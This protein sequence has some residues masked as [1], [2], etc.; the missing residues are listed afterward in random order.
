MQTLLRLR[1]A[2]LVENR[3]SF[4][5]G[6]LRHDLAQGKELVSNLLYKQDAAF[7]A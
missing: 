1:K 5:G 4:D 3:Y 7:D 2:S 6:Q